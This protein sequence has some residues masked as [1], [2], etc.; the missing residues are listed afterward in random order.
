MVVWHNIFVVAGM[1]S[2][3]LRSGM[4]GF[5][6]SPGRKESSKTQTF[7]LIH[8]SLDLNAN[9][10][11]WKHASVLSNFTHCFWFRFRDSVGQ[12]S[13]SCWGGCQRRPSSDWAS[14]HPSPR[15]PLPCCG[16][17]LCCC[18]DSSASMR[19]QHPIPQPQKWADLKSRS[20]VC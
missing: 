6:Y 3:S 12:D 17:A 11:I 4:Q 10:Y 20:D 14:W 8:P 18:G 15:Q 16:G 13:E 1:G 5:G 9:I 19:L 2:E 7:S